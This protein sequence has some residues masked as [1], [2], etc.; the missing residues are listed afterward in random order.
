MRGG[1]QWEIRVFGV[2]YWGWEMGWWEEGRRGR[3]RILR[4]VGL[5]CGFD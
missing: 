1:C 3:G 2:F 4:L 5:F